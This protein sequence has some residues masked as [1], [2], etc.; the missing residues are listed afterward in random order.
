MVPQSIDELP[1]TANDCDSGYLVAGFSGLAAGHRR[2]MVMADIKEILELEREAEA[3][4]DEGKYDDAIARLQ[5]L[6]EKDDSFVRGH[7]ALAMLYERTGKW[8]LAVQHAEKSVDLE[9]GDVLN[10]TALS[11]IYQKAFEATRDPVYIEKAEMAK[12]R[13]ER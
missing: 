13:A 6:L 3:L 2:G 9:P 10:F 8:D 1:D 11:V 4:R 12:A 5:Q 7:L